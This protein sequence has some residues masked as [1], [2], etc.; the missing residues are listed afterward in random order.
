MSLQGAGWRGGFVSLSNCSFGVG[1]GRGSV[2]SY[3]VVFG[4]CVGA[5]K[6]LTYEQASVSAA[7]N[8]AVVLEVQGEEPVL[9]FVHSTSLNS[10]FSFAMNALAVLRIPVSLGRLL[11]R[12][13]RTSSAGWLT[14]ISFAQF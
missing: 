4:C 9:F 6:S 13:L 14:W 8:K 10:Q 3:C 5:D 2:R 12:P 11:C 1:R 7:T